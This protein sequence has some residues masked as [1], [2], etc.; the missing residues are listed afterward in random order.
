[1][2]I[3]DKSSVK[4]IAHWKFENIVFYYDSSLSYNF[5]ENKRSAKEGYTYST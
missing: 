5:E 2:H 1:M 3:Y 4:C